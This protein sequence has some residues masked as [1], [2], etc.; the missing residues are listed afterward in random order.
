M[1]KEG[2]VKI[3]LLALLAT[4]SLAL[5]IAPPARAAALGANEL[6]RV[7]VMEYHQFGLTEQR[8]KRTFDHFREDLAFLYANGYVTV[9][10]SALATG[11]L[12]V[13][14]GKKPVIFTFDDATAGQFKFLHDAQGRVLRGAKGQPRV[15]PQSAVGVMDAFYAAHPDFGRAATFYVLPNAFEVA[16]EAGDKLRYLLATG[17]EV[18]N[19]T[20]DHIALKK[21]NAAKIAS[22]L[23]R[24]QA[25]VARELGHPYPLRTLALPYGIYPK[26]AADTAAVLVGSSGGQRYRNEAVFLVGADP[27][28]SPFDRK[29]NFM[30]VPRIQGIDDEYLRHFRRAKGST[31]P[32][33]EAFKPYVSDGNPA[34]V[35]FPAKLQDRLNARALGSRKAV[36]VAGGG[37]GGGAT[38]TLHVHPGYG[39]AA[40]PPGGEYVG[41]RLFHTV[42]PGQQATWLANQYL[43]MTD[44]YTRPALERDML[45]KNGCQGWIPVGKRIE[46]P[47]A[48]AKAIVPRHDGVPRTFAAKGLYVTKTSA[49]TERVFTLVKQMKPYGL[50]TVVFDVKDMDGVLAYDSQV[51]LAKAVGSGRQAVIRDV[52]KLVDRLHQ[53]GIHVVARQA[54]FHDDF[55]AGRRPDL[56]LKSKSGRPWREH[57]RLVWVDPNNA[58]VRAY[59]L[60][61]SK[62]LAAMG[63]DE[64]QYD[65]VRFPA[66]GALRD[67]AYSFDVARVPKDAVI[68]SY[69][70]DAYRTLHP[71]GVLLSLD[72]FGVVAWDEGIDVRH[73][74][75]K[76]EDLGKVA[77]VISPMVYPSHFY[78]PFFGHTHPADE[79]YFFV[80]EGVKRTAKKTLGSGIVIRPWLQAFNLPSK[81]MVA[82]QYGPDYIRQQIQGAQ[83]AKAIGYLLWNPGNEYGV[84]LKGVAAVGPVKAESKAPLRQ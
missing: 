60:G 23:S 14:A 67:I 79:P 22:Q 24:A 82:H 25:E 76:L 81:K 4:G 32:T 51:P 75:Q 59:N 71:M 44:Y 13:P 49:A 40:L 10:A 27:A 84:G 64:I 11:K 58:Q 9:N 20:Y 15:D 78:P 43:W 77:D 80:N 33:V 54:L 18:G 37:G 38:S 65:Y 42:Q 52:R 30:K 19:H 69:I 3:R 46:I 35:T 45:A 61:I 62:E 6:G 16:A 41:G 66:M 5:A 70:K 31:A 55:L 26:D 48:R 2:R 7:P 17:R 83:D 73:T 63:V 12:D 29:F 21:L 74:G 47:G 53:Q 28:P 39:N 56:A 36:P 72:V 57:G 34:T 68:T 8:W 1:T 50:N